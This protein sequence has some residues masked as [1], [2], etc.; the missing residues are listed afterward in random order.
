MKT[1]T[2]SEGNS[3]RFVLHSLCLGCARVCY[4]GRVGAGPRVHVMAVLS[5]VRSCVHPEEL[6]PLPLV[7]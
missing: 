3:D 2:E 5:H 7:E 1:W 4:K 6:I